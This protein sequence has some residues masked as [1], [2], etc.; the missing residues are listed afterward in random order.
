[1][2]KKLR[3]LEKASQE[4]VHWHAANQEVLG[5]NPRLWMEVL[6]GKHRYA[7]VLYEYW[8]RWQL[9]DTR[10]NFFSWL[11]TGQGSFIDLP[12]AP[13]RLLD[14]WQVVYLKRDEQAIFRVR[15][16]PQTGLLHWENDGTLITVPQPP[17]C[18]KEA[19]SFATDRD[20]L[21]AA[22]LKPRLLKAMSRDQLLADLQAVVEEE[23]RD[24]EAP[25]IEKMEELAEPLIKEGLLC[26]L[27]DPFFKERLD[28]ATTP[29]GHAHLREHPKLPNKLLPGVQWEDFAEAIKHD[30]GQC[31]KTPFPK[32]EERMM[33]KGIFVLDSFGQL[34]CGTKIRGVFHHSSFVRGHCVKV[35]GGI[36]IEDGQLI[37]LSPHSGHYMPGEEHVDDMIKSWKNDGVDFSQVKIKPYLKT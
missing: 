20:R 3:K 34:Y 19:P 35:A 30:E 4:R 14:E 6:D 18:M 10:D 13:K 8:R 23:I 27:R 21:V 31:M 22:L 12:R 16:D 25:H 36:T 5:L 7:S 1:M 28:A 17:F 11:E 26:Q 2:E 33:G 9:S 29:G 32:G 15:I 24:C 37:S